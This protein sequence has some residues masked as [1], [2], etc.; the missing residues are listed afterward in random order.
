MINWI[1]ENN[2]QVDEIK[3]LKKGKNQTAIVD[4]NS[5]LLKFMASRYSDSNDET[6]DD[7]TDD[8][9]PETTDMPDLEREESTEQRRNQEG[10]GLKILIPNQMFS[11]L[12]ITL[13]Q[14]KAGNSSEK[15]KSEIR[16]L[17][18]SLYHSKK[19]SKKIYNGLINTI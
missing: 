18:Y 16:Q 8:E 11:R 7:K 17:L 15:I 14:L 2:S 9:Q 3:K 6:D 10:K 12:P 19:L 13:P 1:K 5:K 4:L